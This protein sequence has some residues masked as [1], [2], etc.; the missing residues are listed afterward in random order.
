[1]N[2]DR[3]RWEAARGAVISKLH[4]KML[5]SL[6]VLVCVSAAHARAANQ[7]ELSV[8][9]LLPD[10]VVEAQSLELDLSPEVRD[11]QEKITIA[12]Q[13]SDKGLLF[14]SMSELKHGEALPYHES[15][16]ISAEE[17]SDAMNDFKRGMDSLSLKPVGKSFDL[18]VANNDATV[19]FK[20]LQQHSPFLK[21]IRIDTVTTE[22]S[23]GE[24]SL[25][26]GTWTSSTSPLSPFG[27]WRGYTWRHSEGH[28][29]KAPYNFVQC[30]LRLVQP[31]GTDNVILH[32][33]M[34][35]VR[36]GV[37]VESHPY[38]IRYQVS[39]IDEAGGLPTNAGD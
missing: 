37:L 13:N 8:A 11:A 25:G 16:G 1:M 6:L 39:G 2:T 31:L 32:T 21:S 7:R 38:L 19:S 14:R 34:R 30:E 18:R 35:R 17:Y 23:F 15:F 36:E 12:I 24:I 5:P 9:D 22:A 10:R 29:L 3:H 26:T 27:P 28:L 4:P 20:P 33:R